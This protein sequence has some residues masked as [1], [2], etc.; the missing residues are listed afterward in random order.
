MSAWNDG[1][2]SIWVSALGGMMFNVHAPL[3]VQCDKWQ[4]FSHEVDFNKALETNRT[5]PAQLPT[6]DRHS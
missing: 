5:P 2:V 3:C 1:L 4:H 6:A